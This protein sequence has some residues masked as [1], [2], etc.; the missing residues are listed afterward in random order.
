VSEAVSDAETTSDDLEERLAAIE[1]RLDAICQEVE[2]ATNRDIPLLKGTVRA[3]IGTEIETIDDLPAAGRAFGQEFVDCKEQLS[4][5]EAQ[6]EVLEQTAD[7]STKAEKIATVLAFASNKGGD[8]A[9]VTVTPAEIRG[10]TGV[11]RRYAYE[12][13]DTVAAEVDGVAVREAKQVQ[14]SSGT[15]RKGKALLVD[16][17]EVHDVSGTVKE[18]T[19]GDGGGAGR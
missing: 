3:V 9:K 8:A 2:T 15:E 7:R 11:S 12:L 16:C 6:L 14:T 10:C 18:F 19:T 13:V 4:Q 17:E 1:R 5:I